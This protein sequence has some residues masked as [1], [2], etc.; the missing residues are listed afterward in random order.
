M[1][2]RFRAWPVLRLTTVP[3]G[4]STDEIGTNSGVLSEALFRVFHSS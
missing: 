3:F 4:H 1:P 2:G